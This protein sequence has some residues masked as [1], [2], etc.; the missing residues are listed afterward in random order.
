MVVRPMLMLMVD[1]INH[2]LNGAIQK[3]IDELEEY[4][5][6]VLVPTPLD[7]TDKN[8]SINGQ[9]TSHSSPSGTNPP[10]NTNGN[11]NSNANGNGNGGASGN[12]TNPSQ[13]TSNRPSHAVSGIDARGV[14]SYSNRQ[15]LENNINNKAPTPT[16][17]P[18]PRNPEQSTNMIT[19]Q[20]PNSIPTFPNSTHPSHILLNLH[21]QQFIESF[22]SLPQ[23]M[24][25]GSST[26]SLAS[27]Q[28]NNLM[29]MSMSISIPN[30]SA[31]RN[32]NGVGGLQQALTAA[33]GLHAEAALLDPSARAVYV[34]EITDAGALF[35]YT[36]PEDS[37]VSGF[38]RQ[39]RRIV[40]AEQVNRAILRMSLF[41]FS[42][43]SLPFPLTAPSL[44]LVS[45]KQPIIHHFS[46][47]YSHPSNDVYPILK[48]TPQNPK[49]NPPKVSSNDSPVEQVRHIPS[50]RMRV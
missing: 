48:L 16:V 25:P 7:G 4:Y 47:S 29:S 39:E 21:I 40:L 38:L 18:P 30:P 23:T 26:S 17:K 15:I 10:V 27:N 35:A 13:G 5:P 36:D 8:G 46:F 6:A 44:N 22:R 11:G 34:R 31:S 12:G 19:N 50:S 9:G 32:G 41:F 45:T 3:A 1:I 14:M 43:L 37:P 33:S 49:V 2:I 20:L 42:P 24:S 28:N